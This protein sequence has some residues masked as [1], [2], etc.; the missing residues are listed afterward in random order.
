MISVF[1]GKHSMSLTITVISVTIQ[2]EPSITQAIVR[3]PSVLAV[4][5]TSVSTLSAL[6]NV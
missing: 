5:F 3:A 6:I 2:P 4:L 1:Y